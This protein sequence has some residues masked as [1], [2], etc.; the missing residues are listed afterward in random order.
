[1]ESI[2]IVLS[3]LAFAL[4]IFTYF[5]HDR[6]LKKQEQKL[7]DYKM[8]SLAQ[9]E[10]E[11]KKAVIRAEALKNTN[12]KRTLYIK[13]RGKAIAYNLKVDILDNEQVVASRPELPQT[14][15]ELL[16]DAS[17]KILLLLTEGD[18]EITV[19]FEWEDDFKK[20]NK[21]SQTI[22]L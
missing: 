1:M 10:E 15:D 4:S 8:R 17:R 11:G 3:V 22:D 18:D 14:Y 6:R 19:T 16:P 20:D 12:G 7:N 9:S 21:D 2:S 5:A 13:N